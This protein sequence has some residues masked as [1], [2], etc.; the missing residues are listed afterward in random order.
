[1]M[2]PAETEAALAASKVNLALLVELDFAS[3]PLRLWTGLGTFAW[4]GMEFTGAG[5]LAAV[6]EVTSTAEP[7]STAYTL[8]LASMPTSLIAI[9]ESDRWKGR[10]ARL[11]IAV[12]D[13]AGALIGEPLG[14]GVGRMDRLAWTM[15][16]TV[17]FT[18]TVETEAAAISRPSIRRY[19]AEDQ[20]GE[21]PGDAAFDA[22][23]AL[24]GRQIMWGVPN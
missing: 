9:A 7:R 5:D 17:S 22:V 20:R 12:L 18:L 3:G 10:A 4:A 23:A 2:I 11:W 21:Y 19:T 16:E 13:D 24:Q 8:T 14:P 15:G 6:S 1:M